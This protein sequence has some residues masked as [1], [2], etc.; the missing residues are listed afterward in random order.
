MPQR[1]RGQQIRLWV[2]SLCCA[3]PGAIMVYV[4]Q[5]FWKGAGLF[6]VLA[7]VLGVALFLVEKQLAHKRDGR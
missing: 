4:T 5:S 3:L 1:S 7:V 2:M 6:L